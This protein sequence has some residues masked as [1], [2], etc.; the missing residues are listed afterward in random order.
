MS[1]LPK[2][3]L[4]EVI[5]ELRWQI[6]QKSDLTKYQYLIGDLYSAIKQT[7]PERESLAPPEVPVDFLINSPV[8]RFRKDKNQYPLVQIGPG[9][10]T[11]NTID[12]NYHWNDFYS[13]AEALNNVFFSV[14]QLENETFR[15]NLLYL[16]FFKFDFINN[17]VNEFINKSFNIIIN[18][19]FIEETG[20]PF[21]LDIGFFYNTELGNLSVTLKKGQNGKKEDGIV[22]QT[23]LN[24][25]DSMTS[26]VNV[27]SWLNQAHE[28][29]SKIF[30]EITKGELY[31][32]FK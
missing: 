8:H 9:V 1:K 23:S 18:Q 20:N 2:A 31:N 21:H 16:D 30:K 13:W 24:G 25:K 10:L 7:Y 17:N 28:F 22:M 27:L 5:F 19:G 14:F 26:S 6:K 11:L 3:P 4:L 12:E 32:S 15:S 29:S